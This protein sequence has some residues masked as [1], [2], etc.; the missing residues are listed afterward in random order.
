MHGNQQYSTRLGGQ[1]A[2]FHLQAPS[3]FKKLVFGQEG[4]GSWSRICAKRGRKACTKSNVSP[5]TNFWP[6]RSAVRT[7]TMAKRCGYPSSQNQTPSTWA[8]HSWQPGCLTWNCSASEKWCNR[9]Y[10]LFP[11]TS[12]NINQ[13]KVIS[14][15][16]GSQ[17]L[18]S[19]K[20]HLKK[21]GSLVKSEFILTQRKTDAYLAFCVDGNTSW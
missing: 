7:V 15:H 16:R 20:C 1:S 10:G 4:E 21:N 5:K 9:D 8:D 17:A 11:V 14:H 13:P 19:S 12:W 18:H 3:C 6:K 2:T